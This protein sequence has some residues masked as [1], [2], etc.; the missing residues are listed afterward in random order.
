MLRPAFS[1]TGGG[2]QPIDR[3]GKSDLRRSRILDEFFH[4]GRIGRQAGQIQR[5]APQKGDPVC[6]CC[7]F[8]IVLTQLPT[9]KVINGIAFGRNLYALYRLEGPMFF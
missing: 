3:F 7:K 2:Q 4:R 6:L 1:I 8:Q 5:C 9:N